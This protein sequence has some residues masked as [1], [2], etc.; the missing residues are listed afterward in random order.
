MRISDYNYTNMDESKNMDKEAGNKRRHS[1]WFQE[2]LI[3]GARN[4]NSSY[5]SGNSIGTRM[6]TKGALGMLIMFSFSNCVP[7][8]QMFSLCEND[9]S[10]Y[11]RVVYFSVSVKCQ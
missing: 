11:L 2:K 7:I 4:Q 8:T 6:T 10:V 1:V 9:Q 5:S 3:F